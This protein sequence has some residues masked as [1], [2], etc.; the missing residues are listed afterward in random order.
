MA[1]GGGTGVSISGGVAALTWRL[2]PNGAALITLE[3]GTFISEGK[4]LGL[5][6]T[7][8]LGGRAAFNLVWWEERIGEL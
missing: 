2:E 7:F 6:A 1:A 8:E 3:S 4:N 5:Q